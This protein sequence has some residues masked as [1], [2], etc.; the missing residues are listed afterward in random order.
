M[1]RSMAPSLL[2]KLRECGVPEHSFNPMADRGI[3]T[4]EDLLNVGA[5]TLRAFGVLE[6]PR[7]KIRAWACSQKCLFELHLYSHGYAV[8]SPAKFESA[9]DYVQWTSF[10]NRLVKPKD[11]D[12]LELCWLLG[13]SKLAV[14]PLADAAGITMESLTLQ[15]RQQPNVGANQRPPSPEFPEASHTLSSSVHQEDDPARWL[16]QVPTYEG[17]GREAD[18]RE[19]IKIGEG[20]R[21]APLMRSSSRKSTYGALQVPDDLFS[22][23][24]ARSTTEGPGESRRYRTGLEAADDVAS[25]I[26]AGTTHRSPDRSSVSAASRH[27]TRGL[28]SLQRLSTANSSTATPASSLRSSHE[29]AVNPASFASAVAA[30]VANTS[31]VGKTTSATVLVL[32]PFERSATADPHVRQSRSSAS[33]SNIGFRTSELS[34]AFSSSFRG[35]SIGSSSSSGSNWSS[36]PTMTT[37][38]LCEAPALRPGMKRRPLSTLRTSAAEGRLVVGRNAAPATVADRLRRTAM[39]AGSRERHQRDWPRGR[40]TQLAASGTLI[41]HRPVFW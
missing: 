37:T 18:P 16:N 15:L 23:S 11:R 22:E 17:D 25:S 30:A 27:G 40:S 26:G 14:R 31:E 20:K 3:C 10:I 9:V 41:A 33:G 8:G 5:E 32:P 34:G 36:G 24:F 7:A 28:V 38:V 21:N 2:A 39:P 4:L 1:K 6:E 35:S 12:Y 19:G 13:E 29:A